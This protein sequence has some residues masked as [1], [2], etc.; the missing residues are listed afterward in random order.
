MSED[1]KLKLVLDDKEYEFEIEDLSQEGKAQYTR[2]NQ[3]AG[4]LMRLD[5]QSNELRFLANNYIRFVTDEL[6]K[7]KSVDDKSKK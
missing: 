1:K 5:Q 2:A 3:L 4:E 6:D 7:D